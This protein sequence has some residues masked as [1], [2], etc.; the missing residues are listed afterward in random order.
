MFFHKCHRFF[1]KE[2]ENEYITENIN[3]IVDRNAFHLLDIF[4]I[5][6]VWLSIASSVV[7]NKAFSGYRLTPIGIRA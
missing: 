6:E 5:Q 1:L 4:R 7:S 2:N 3:E